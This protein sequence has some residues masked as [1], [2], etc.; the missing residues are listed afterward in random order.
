VIFKAGDSG[1]TAINGFHRNDYSF[2][3]NYR[4]GRRVARVRANVHG[5]RRDEMG[6]CIFLGGL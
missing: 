1:A 4:Q 3:G 5:F 6:G 2:Y